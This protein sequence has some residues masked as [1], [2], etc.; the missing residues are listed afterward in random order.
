MIGGNVTAAAIPQEIL[1]DDYYEN[2]HGAYN[3]MR[4]RFAGCA[5]AG[6]TQDHLAT[7]LDVDKSLISKRINGKEN[8]TLKTLSFMATAM[9][10]RIIVS[11]VPYEQLGR[12]N[13]YYTT[14]LHAVTA[15][16]SSSG[17]AT[18]SQ[19]VQVTPANK[20][21]RELEKVE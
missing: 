5:A 14:P 8:L 10:C 12:S 15:T 20:T 11:F 9:E 7:M 2:L 6:L 18:I 4:E 1:W 13:Y 3:S 16:S 17:A 19:I 21:T